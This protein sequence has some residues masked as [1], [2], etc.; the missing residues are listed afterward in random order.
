VSYLK[1]WFKGPGSWIAPPPRIERAYGE[2]EEQ[3]ENLKKHASKQR[4]QWTPPP[5]PPKQQSPPVQQE[6][7][8]LPHCFR[9]IVRP[10]I[11]SAEGPEV[12]VGDPLDHLFVWAPGDI[13]G[14]RERARSGALA[15]YKKDE[16]MGHL[17]AGVVIDKVEDLGIV[18]VK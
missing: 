4:P 12:T 6:K 2:L 11:Q 13:E 14:L 16:M 7:P 5:L 10:V 18:N 1:D 17:I 15:N 3:I 8:K 9:V